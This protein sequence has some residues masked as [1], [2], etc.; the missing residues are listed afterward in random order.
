[1]SCSYIKIDNSTGVTNTDITFSACSP[2][3]SCVYTSFIVAPGEIY[4]VNASDLILN[5][6]TATITPLS[7]VVEFPSDQTNIFNFSSV[8][9]DDTFFIYS[10]TSGEPGFVDGNYY[11]L[12]GVTNCDNP[13][14][15]YQPQCYQLVSTGVDAGYPYYSTFSNPSY[16]GDDP[17]DC[18]LVCSCC[19][20]NVIDNGNFDVDLY[21]WENPS[22]NWGWTSYG[23]Q[24]TGATGTGDFL[25]QENVLTENCYYNISFDI[26][27]N[28]ETSPNGYVTYSLGDV[29]GLTYV[30]STSV[31]VTLLCTGNTSF[32]IYGYLGN[33]LTSVY[34]DNICVQLDSCI[35]IEC[36]VTNYCVSNTGYDFDGQYSISSSTYNSNSL[37]Y[38]SDETYFIYFSSSE[39]QWCLSSTIGGTCLLSGKSPCTS[40]C[41]DLCEDYLFDTICPTPTPT[42]TY[43]CSSFD[44][45]G[46][47]DC[48]H[49]P[50]PTPTLTSTPTPTS[51]CQ[52]IDVDAEINTTTSTPTPTPMLTPTPTSTTVRSCD[53][54]GTVTFNVIQAAL[55]CPFSQQFQ[56]CNTGVYYYTSQN[57]TYPGGGSL[58]QY[59]VFQANVDGQVKCITYIGGNADISGGNNIELLS[60]AYG[61]SIAGACSLCTVPAAP[62][63][64]STLPP[65]QT[66]TSSSSI[67]VF[68]TP[69]PTPTFNPPPPN[70]G[71]NIFVNLRNSITPFVGSVWYSYYFGNVSNINING[72]NQ[73]VLG[74]N[75]VQLNTKSL[76]QCGPGDNFLGNVPWINNPLYHIVI[77]VRNSSNTLIYRCV[78]GFIG[79]VSDPCSPS[80]ALQQLY[81]SLFQA[82]LTPPVEDIRFL[83]LN[84]IQTIPL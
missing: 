31:N 50:T 33:S 17:N 55:D 54:S 58:L 49:T 60:G 25:Y 53:F 47:F 46:L 84:P 51:V 72:S 75:W 44:F 74:L 65:T 4:Y 73:S 80:I 28:A 16:L 70:S 8:C 43:N 6:G 79:E 68:S 71:L 2:S 35:P 18:L 9:N 29:S 57:L 5:S 41:P 34:V 42:P 62:T 27:I 19:P 40:L 67:I 15:P 76:L 20:Y 32:F 30:S 78:A 7:S 59:M 82:H 81:T 12:S 83:V 52:L 77:Q 22:G 69:T 24:Y 37:Y 13:N 23:A 11:C 39:N 45:E 63:P 64:T 3:A 38:N 10:K 66:P 1:M 26:F 56:D 36:E 61:Y 48:L 14:S 21:G